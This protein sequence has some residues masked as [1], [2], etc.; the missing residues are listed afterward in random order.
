[1]NSIIK[2]A[3]YLFVFTF[4]RFIPN[5]VFTNLLFWINCLRHKCEFY[6]IN[7]NKPRTFNE[8]INYIKFNVKNRHS[9][10][11]ADKYTARE[12]VK[13]TIG[14]EFLIPLL[15]VFELPEEINFDELP[16]QFII[17]FNNGSGKNFIVRDKDKS[18]I[19]KVRNF[20]NDAYKQKFFFLSREWHYDKIKPKILVEKYLGDNINDYKIFC[21]NIE[22]PFLIQ[23]D[24]ARFVNHKRNFYDPSW[25]PVKLEFV[26]PNSNII[27]SKPVNLDLMLELAKKLSNE[28]IFCRVDF[29]EIEGRIFFGEITLHPEGGVGPFKNFNNDLELGKFIS[30]GR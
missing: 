29:Y 28:F 2:K 24:S 8:K 23:V 21:N 19:I 12:F 30:I 1:M 3:L 20:F 4:N 25:S 14:S 15:K 16:S 5:I 6:I 22:G 26:Y 11:V 18:D 17:K 27:D 13:N 10:D 7:F 9:V